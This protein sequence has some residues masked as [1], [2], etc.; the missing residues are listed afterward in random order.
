MKSRIISVSGKGRTGKTTLVALLLK[1]L[2]KS[3]KYDSIL[4]VDADSAT[5]LPGVLGIE[6]EKTVGMVA[7]ELKKI[8]KGLIPIGVSKSNPLEAWMYSTLVELQDFDY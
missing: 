5:N 3:N 7:N 8:E 4:V 1:V 2:L 6:V